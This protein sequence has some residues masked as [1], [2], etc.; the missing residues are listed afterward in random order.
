MIASLAITLALAFWQP[1]NAGQPVCPSGV[2]IGYYAPGQGPAQN[3]YA[4][5]WTVRD[6]GCDIHLSTT[7]PEQLVSTQCALVAHELGHSVFSLP[8]ETTD[9]RNVMYDPGPAEL[10]VVP[11]ACWPGG[12]PAP[13]SDRPAGHKRKRAHRRHR[14]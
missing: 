6:G 2:S 14:H 3:P 10:I 13:A 12:P 1:Y 11:A 4:N 7:I 5:G 8:D 9:P